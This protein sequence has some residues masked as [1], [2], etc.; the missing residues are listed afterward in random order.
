M[1]CCDRLVVSNYRGNS[2]EIFLEFPMILHSRTNV[3]KGGKNVTPWK[4][5]PYMYSEYD[6][7]GHVV[8][9]VFTSRR[10]Y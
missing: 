5:P 9:N 8:Y 10:E 7:R 6:N 4:N 3:P 1:D 2:G